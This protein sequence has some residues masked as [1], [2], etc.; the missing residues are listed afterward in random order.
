MKYVGSE[1]ELFAQAR[2]WKSYFCTQIKPFLGSEVVEVGAGLAGTT[3]VLLSDGARHQRWV[4]L[5]PDP[6]LCEHI[7]PGRLPSFVEVQCSTLEPMADASFDSILYIDVLE[8]IEH[9][10]AELESALRRLRPGGHLIVLSP[11]HQFLYS[12]FDQAIGHFR[13]YSRTALEACGPPGSRLVRSRYLDSLGFFLSLANSR[14]LRQS[15]PT[16]RQVAFWDK[17]VVP[18]SRRL[19][20]LLGYH[21]G[22]SV[23]CIWQKGWPASC[24]SG[25]TC[26]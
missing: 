3:R 26:E 25:R 7:E 2:N 9:D 6:E 20:P 5:E 16:P 24:P 18:I 22:K 14:M 15:M 4:C 1:L 23:L 21:F 12:P 11:A 10:R 13:R 19:D 8:H 17:V